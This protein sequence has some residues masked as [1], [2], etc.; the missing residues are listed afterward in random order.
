ML[1]CRHRK[2]TAHSL[3]RGFAG[4]AASNG[5]DVKSLMAHVGW[6][7]MKSALR[8]VDASDG[9]VAER[10]E[11]G[12]QSLAIPSVVVQPLAALSHVAEPPA[13]ANTSVLL[14]LKMKLSLFSRMAA[15]GKTRARRLIEELCLQP[16]GM[17][18][19]DP[20]GT[21]YE[22]QFS[23]APG[24]VLD[25]TIHAVLEEMHRIAEDHRCFLDATFHE[26]GTDRY[27]D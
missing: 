17:T 8:Y 19:S 15:R 4:W 25:D 22:L 14:E 11:Q 20:A 2:A 23:P 7:D 5:W 1:E 12:L 9:A 27:W 21:R 18:R 6:R 24:E 10:I 16:H 13:A 3:R 26:Q